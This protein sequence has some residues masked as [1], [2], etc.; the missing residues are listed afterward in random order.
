LALGW[1]CGAFT[2]LAAAAYAGTF[3]HGMLVGRRVPQ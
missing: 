3:L 2:V 1:A